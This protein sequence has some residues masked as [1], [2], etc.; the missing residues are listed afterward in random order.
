MRITYRLLLSLL[1]VA[2]AATTQET[3][4]AIDELRGS[5]APLE[6]VLG[7]WLMTAKAAYDS[8]AWEEFCAAFHVDPQWPSAQTLGTV[9]AR[10]EEEYRA[11]LL[12]ARDHPDYLSTD[13]R[14]PNEWREEAMGR[15]FA[16]VI[17]ALLHDG[18]DVSLPAL[19]GLIEERVRG[20][21]TYYSDDGP[22]QRTEDELALFWVGAHQ[23]MVG[24]R[25]KV[26]Q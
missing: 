18:Y 24:L 8:P 23:V 26:S 12:E 19:V 22:A 4:P 2:A 20:G 6:M 16:E 25:A 10:T 1:L 9:A 15:A 7:S 17:E 5:D 11:R 14:N 3:Q 13:G 21:V